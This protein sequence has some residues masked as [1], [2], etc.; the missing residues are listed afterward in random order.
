VFAHDESVVLVLVVLVLVEFE[1]DYDA[2][3]FS[4]KILIYFVLFFLN[5][6]RRFKFYVEVGHA[7]EPSPYS[8][9]IV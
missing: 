6:P 2:P 3:Q 4:I 1:P 8:A 5:V 9:N 7:K